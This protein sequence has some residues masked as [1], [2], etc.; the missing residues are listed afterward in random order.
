MIQVRNYKT[1]V[2]TGSAAK[3]LFKEIISCVLVI[4]KRACI[5]YCLKLNKQQTCE[6]FNC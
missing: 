5:R 6:V 1:E 2:S 3:I 4:E